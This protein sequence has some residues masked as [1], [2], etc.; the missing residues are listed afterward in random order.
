MSSI[1]GNVFSNAVQIEARGITSICTIN[2]TNSLGSTA[3]IRT[4]ITGKTYVTFNI[5]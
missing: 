2:L 3:T 4:N 5:K 1:S